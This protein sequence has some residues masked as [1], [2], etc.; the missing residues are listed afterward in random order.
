MA[1]KG[2]TT[3]VVNGGEAHGILT[4]RIG[5]VACHTN[6]SLACCQFGNGAVKVHGN[7]LQFQTQ[8]VSNVVTQSNVK[9]GQS[10]GAGI[11]Q[12][13]ELVGGEVGRCNHGQLAAVNGLQQGLQLFDGHS[14][15]VSIINS[16]FCAAAGQQGQNQHCCQHNRNN[17]FH[18]QNSP[19]QIP[20]GRRGQLMNEL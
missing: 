11:V 2:L 9:T 20:L 7:D 18:S 8:E 1:N 10:G 19:F 12:R 14:G 5:R 15:I 4:V 13:V 17:L 3:G 16:G 6:V